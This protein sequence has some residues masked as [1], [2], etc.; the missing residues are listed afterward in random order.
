MLTTEFWIAMSFFGK[1]KILTFQYIR[2]FKFIIKRICFK[3]STLEADMSVVYRAD[4]C[5]SCDVTLL[6]VVDC[7]KV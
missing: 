7:N 6:S 2:S 5:V 4:S 3:V 1:Q